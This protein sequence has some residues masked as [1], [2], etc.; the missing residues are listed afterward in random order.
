MS[1][2]LREA[3]DSGWQSIVGPI[4]PNSTVIDCVQGVCRSDAQHDDLGVIGR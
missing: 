1:F 2:I 4:R 3:Y